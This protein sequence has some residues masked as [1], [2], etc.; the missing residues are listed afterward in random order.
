MDARATARALET[1]SGPQG[2]P[3]PR[4]PGHSFSQSAQSRPPSL[5]PS[6]PPSPLTPCLTLAPCP[7]LPQPPGRPPRPVSRPAGLTSHGS[8]PQSQVRTVTRAEGHCARRGARPVPAAPPYTSPQ[9][10]ST[11]CRLLYWATGSRVMCA[12]LI[13]HTWAAGEQLFTDIWI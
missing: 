4:T 2:S 12:G 1:H 10:P 11:G 9:H 8:A 7:G 5:R 13:E 6:P 3:A